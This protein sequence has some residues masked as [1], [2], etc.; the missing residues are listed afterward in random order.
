MGLI[1]FFQLKTASQRLGIM[2]FLEENQKL[3]QVWITREFRCSS[4][5]TCVQW[6]V[7]SQTWMALWLLSS[8]PSS[9]PKQKLMCQGVVSIQVLFWEAAGMWPRCPPERKDCRCHHEECY[10]D[11]LFVL[12][13]Q[14]QGS[15]CRNVLLKLSESAVPVCGHPSLF[16]CHLLPPESRQT[17]GVKTDFYLLEIGTSIS[18]IHIE[19]GTRKIPSTIL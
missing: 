19:E 3:A 13:T 14:A 12:P 16:L 17:W 11:K 2:S 7:Y 8:D 15:V 1:M 5:T 4:Q 9:F 18:Q 10:S 6:C